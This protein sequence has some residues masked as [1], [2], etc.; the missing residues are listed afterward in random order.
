MI[1]V[2]VY[3]PLN[4]GATSWNGIAEFRRMIGGGRKDVRSELFF[5]SE[6]E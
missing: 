3:V 6:S 2:N 4:F 5:C 1:V